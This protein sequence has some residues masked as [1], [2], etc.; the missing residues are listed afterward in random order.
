MIGAIVGAVIAL[1]VVL[2]VI[3][4]FVIKRRQ[5]SNDKKS[6]NSNSDRGET[7]TT[8]PPADDSTRNV[9]TRSHEYGNVQSALS[10]YS[11]YGA[12]PPVSEY[13]AASS[14]LAME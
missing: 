9:S 12:A 4:L 14:P 6:G 1:I 7:P 2:I 11:Q 8:T 13:D 10:Q 3:A 5:S